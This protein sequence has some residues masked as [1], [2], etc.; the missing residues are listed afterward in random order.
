M[1]AQRELEKW[2]KDVGI[3]AIQR[4]GT[5]L[6]DCGDPMD[7]ELESRP[8]SQQQDLSKLEIRNGEIVLDWNYD[9]Y[10]E[11]SFGSIADLDKRW[12]HVLNNGL[13]G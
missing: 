10:G 8:S 9:G 3:V 12:L 13:E 5:L 7:P 1:V 4:E 6:F 11:E 2:V